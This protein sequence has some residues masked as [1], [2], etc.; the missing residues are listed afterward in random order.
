MES[1][2]IQPIARVSNAKNIAAKIKAHVNSRGLTIQT[3][4]VLIQIRQYFYIVYVKNRDSPIKCLIDTAILRFIA[5]NKETTNLINTLH[6]VDVIE[7]PTKR[8]LYPNTQCKILDA[9]YNYTIKLNDKNEIAACIG[10]QFPMDFFCLNNDQHDKNG[11]VLSN[12]AHI[13]VYVSDERLS[14][15]NIASTSWRTSNNTRNSKYIHLRGFASGCW[16]KLSNS[17]Q[18]LEIVNENVKLGTVTL[19]LQ[20]SEAAMQTRFGNEPS[21]I[22]C[23]ILAKNKMKLNKYHEL[24]DDFS[25]KQKH[26]VEEESNESVNVFELD[27]HVNEFKADGHVMVSLHK[28]NEFTKIFQSIPESFMHDLE[29]FF[30]PVY[31]HEPQKDDIREE[32]FVEAADRTSS[33]QLPSLTGSDVNHTTKRIQELNSKFESLSK[34]L[35]HLPQTNQPTVKLDLKQLMEHKLNFV[36][37]RNNNQTKLAT[38]SV[39]INKDRMSAFSAR[40]TSVANGRSDIKQRMGNLSHRFHSELERKTSNSL[41]SLFNK[42]VW[43]ISGNLESLQDN[44]IIRLLVD[45]HLLSQKALFNPDMISSNALVINLRF[46]IQKQFKQVYQ[47]FCIYSLAYDMSNIGDSCNS[48]NSPMLNYAG[49]KQFWQD[50]KTTPS[51]DINELDKLLNECIISEVTDYEDIR[52]DIQQFVTILVRFSMNHYKS[53]LIKSGLGSAVKNE[54]RQKHKFKHTSASSEKT[55]THAA[56]TKTITNTIAIANKS[57]SKKPSQ[58]SKHIKQ[59][60]LVSQLM[61]S[62][63]NASVFQSY[64]MVSI[65]NQ[66]QRN[67]FVLSNLFDKLCV[68]VLQNEHANSAIRRIDEIDLDTAIKSKQLSELLKIKQIISKNQ[69]LDPQT[70]AMITDIKYADTVPVQLKRIFRV[71]AQKYS[72]MSNAGMINKSTTKSDE[73]L[74]GFFGFAR[75][76]SEIFDLKLIDIATIFQISKE[77]A[78]NG[79]GYGFN[80]MTFDAFQAAIIRCVAKSTGMAPLIDSLMMSVSDNPK[81]LSSCLKTVV[82][83]LSDMCAILSDVSE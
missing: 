11:V 43:P 45:C 22:N 71:L 79:C 35:N 56:E 29:V 53:A 69:Y 59:Q 46:G 24:T 12:M 57:D 64:Q 80:M 33:R 54:K 27:F 73:I 5:D 68:D 70:N 26:Q 10:G 41:A 16:E 9:E 60:N 63:N 52:I 1:S 32:T 58:K 75:F 47:L 82:N 78:E 48:G 44:A 67:S 55:V 51:Y 39:D 36:C 50:L 21:A 49:L 17:R 4:P 61:K 7:Y 77:K 62:K 19:T 2:P 74:L 20:F 42:E 65:M 38:T 23:L 81:E 15:R 40:K 72:D 30:Q 31:L 8:Q 18:E 14:I 6:V 66:A 25:Q 83:E 3:F 28:R 76:V 13:K 34:T 37:P